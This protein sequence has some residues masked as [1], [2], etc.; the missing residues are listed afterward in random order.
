MIQTR[1]TA[2]IGPLH[3]NGYNY[4]G[5]K[6]QSIPQHPTN[7]GP[8]TFVSSCSLH[9]PVVSDLGFLTLGNVVDAL[10]YLSEVPRP[11]L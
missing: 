9:Y 10:G 3:Q 7:C 6:I 11:N 1:D 5:E 2:R 4:N 8:A